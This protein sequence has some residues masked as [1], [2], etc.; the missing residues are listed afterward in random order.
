MDLSAL[1]I[2]QLRYL[3]AV[4]RHRSFRNA[5]LA[6][7]V[8]QPALSMQIKRLEEILDV[9]IFDRSKQPVTV[10]G[11][12]AGIVADANIKLGHFHRIGTLAGPHS[13]RPG[14]LPGT[15]RVGIIPTLAPTFVPI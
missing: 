2:Q 10:T 6:S 3:V 7:H 12:C 13:T 11:E 15:V 14:D 5:A 1:T 4:E 8:S 9:Q